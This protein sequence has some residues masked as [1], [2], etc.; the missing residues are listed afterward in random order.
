MYMGSSYGQ[1]DTILFSK[2]PL[3]YISNYWFCR[4]AFSKR[5]IN[6]A[7]KLVEQYWLS[8]DNLSLE[9]FSKIESAYKSYL[10][11]LYKF[12]WIYNSSKAWIV[13]VMCWIWDYNE[14][15]M[16]KTQWIDFC[17]SWCEWHEIWYKR[18]SDNFLRNKEDCSGNSQAFIEWCISYIYDV[19][20]CN[21][22]W[23]TK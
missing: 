1:V 10:D 8:S 21:E 20:Y 12:V 14:S 3:S 9:A 2:N 4:D 17:K 22:N 13:D 18:A 19:N 7:N 15:Y 5:L 16:Y 11:G 6:D 23:N